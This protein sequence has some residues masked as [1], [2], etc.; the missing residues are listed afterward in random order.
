M[1]LFLRLLAA[2]VLITT[3]H[4]S[5]EAMARTITDIKEAGDCKDPSLLRF[6]ADIDLIP[7]AGLETFFDSRT[8]TT[9]IRRG[10]STAETRN[11]PVPP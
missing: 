7:V 4:F 6:A 9:D 5:G 1:K 11:V 8:K 2:A 10:T 3:L